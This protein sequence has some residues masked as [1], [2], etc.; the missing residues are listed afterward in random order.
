MSCISSQ[1]E[2]YLICARSHSSGSCVNWHAY[3][4]GGFGIN[5]KVLTYCGPES[6]YAMFVPVEEQVLETQIIMYQKQLEKL[7]KLKQEGHQNHDFG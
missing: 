5:S 4:Y 1:C 3:G 6:N 7:K 2:R